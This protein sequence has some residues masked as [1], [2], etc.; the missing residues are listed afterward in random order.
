MTGNKE[1]WKNWW[2][3]GPRDEFIAKELKEANLE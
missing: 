1:K 3:N 2:H